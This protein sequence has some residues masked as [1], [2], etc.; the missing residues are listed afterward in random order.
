MLIGSFLAAAVALTSPASA[1]G[2]GWMVPALHTGDRIYVS[3]VMRSPAWDK[4][5]T[6]VDLHQSGYY[7]F[8]DVTDTQAPYVTHSEVEGTDDS[9]S[10]MLDLVALTDSDNDPQPAAGGSAAEYDMPLYNPAFFG[11]IPA[12]VAVGTTWTFQGPAWEFGPSVLETIKAR[13]VDPA[14]RE[15]SLEI[16]GTG[17]GRPAATSGNLQVW[18]D[19]ANAFVDVDFGRTT[20]TMYVTYRNGLLHNLDFVATSE[21]RTVGKPPIGGINENATYAFYETVIYEP[22]APRSA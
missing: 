11:A 18:L 22:K 7:E 6:L 2:L 20:W 15:L 5:H 4:A 16:H 9:V 1:G 19:A 17:T 21:R 3:S 10:G 12:N 8:T 13:T 14:A